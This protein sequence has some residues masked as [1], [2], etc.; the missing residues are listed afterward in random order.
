MNFKELQVKVTNETGGS[1]FLQGQ[2]VINSDKFGV[3]IYPEFSVIVDSPLTAETLKGFY[4]EHNWLL[5]EYPELAVG[6]WVHE[7][8][9][10]LD[11][12]VVVPTKDHALC[13]AKRYSQVAIWDFK[14]NKEVLL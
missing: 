6:T 14:N 10:Y 4:A 13:I 9:V 3:S 12:S 8:K 1:T 5:A 7:G 11:L 2:Q